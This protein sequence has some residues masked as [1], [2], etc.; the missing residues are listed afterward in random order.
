MKRY[1]SSPQYLIDDILNLYRI[2]F[3]APILIFCINLVI[4]LQHHNLESIQ[5]VTEI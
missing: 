3:V 5:K 4:E 1:K 2:I